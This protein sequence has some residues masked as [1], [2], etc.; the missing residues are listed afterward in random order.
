MIGA[1]HYIGTQVLCHLGTLTTYFLL[2]RTQ[3]INQQE[4]IE[5]KLLTSTL[6][7]H[8]PSPER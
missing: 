5:M 6:Y 8:N 4:I 7:L 1:L 2:G 3:V